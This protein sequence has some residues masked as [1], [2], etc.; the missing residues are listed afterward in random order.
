MK[1]FPLLSDVPQPRNISYYKTSLSNDGLYIFY[2]YDPSILSSEFLTEY[3]KLLGE[4]G[5]MFNKVEIESDGTPHSYFTKDNY[6]TS[7]SLV[8]QD[9]VIFGE[10]H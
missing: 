3:F 9:M 4:N 5:W 7:I 1:F 6:I 8:G 2:H 10:A